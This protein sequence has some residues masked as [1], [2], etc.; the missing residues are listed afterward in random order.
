MSQYQLILG[1]CLEKLRELPADSIDSIVTDPPAGIGFMGKEWDSDKGGRD[2]WIAWLSAISKEMIR[3]L[4]PGGHALVWALPRTSH[5]TATALE[6]AGFEV[7][8]RVHHIFG[9]G[10]PK[11]LNVIKSIAGQCKVE[12]QRVKSANIHSFLNASTQGTDGRDFAV[13]AVL[14]DRSADVAN[15]GV[16]TVSPGL[17]Y[18]NRA[19]IE[20]KVSF[21]V[22]SVRQSGNDSW[23]VAATLIGQ[24]GTS[25]DRTVMSLSVQ[26]TEAIA[27]NTI[28]SLK[29]LLDGGSD[30][31]KTSITGME[32]AQTTAL[33]IWNSLQFL[34]T[35][36]SISAVNQ[37]ALKPAVEDWWLVRKP[38]EEKTVAKQVLATGTG[39][40]N[41]DGCRVGGG[42]GRSESW[43]RSGHSAKPEE[44]KIAAPPGVGINQHPEGRWPAHLVFTHADDC[45]NVGAASATEVISCA[46]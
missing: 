25:L 27:L 4:K 6:D 45:I 32:I 42:Y 2:A 18:L 43:G 39:A 3:V 19:V 13:V 7:R 16:Y 28:S 33:Q 30:L 5:W 40:I 24:G 14:E 1:D 8:D 21:A 26:T 37:T 38:L 10:F 36:D 46:S 20:E 29:T 12:T 23:S 35:L 44:E 34:S 11:S 9:S 15:D 22:L 31:E 41:V 17:S